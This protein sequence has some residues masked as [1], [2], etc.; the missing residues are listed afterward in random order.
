M[1][2]ARGH[3]KIIID[4]QIGEYL[5]WFIRDENSVQN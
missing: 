2:T 1:E 5:Q 4:I 3:T